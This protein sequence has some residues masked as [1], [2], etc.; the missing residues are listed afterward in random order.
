MNGELFTRAILFILGMHLTQVA[1]IG[2][3]CDYRSPLPKCAQAACIGPSGAARR[4]GARKTITVGL[5]GRRTP[6]THTAGAVPGHC[7]EP[8]SAG[9]HKIL[10]LPESSAYPV[11]SL[12]E[13][14]WPPSRRPECVARPGWLQVHGDASWRGR[15]MPYYPSSGLAVHNPAPGGAAVSAGGGRSRSIAHRFAASFA[16]H[17]PD[18]P[19]RAP[20]PA[21]SIRTAANRDLLTAGPLG[22]FAAGSA[23]S[24]WFFPAIALPTAT[25]KWPL[26]PRVR[27]E[28]KLSE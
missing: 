22:G 3:G 1:T 4:L 19:S 27:H 11:Y 2:R 5:I 17:R 6:P 21:P 26:P 12:S 14:E 7:C 24:G 25:S 13:A 20:R 15:C 10:G 16:Y 28:P 23:S 8:R 9:N 18:H